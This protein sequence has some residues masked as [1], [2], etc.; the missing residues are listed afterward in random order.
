MN[1]PS[2]GCPESV[3]AAWGDAIYPPYATM[4]WQ[5]ERWDVCYDTA[6]TISEVNEPSGV[7]DPQFVWFMTRSLD[8]SDLPT[9]DSDYDPTLRST[10][11]AADQRLRASVR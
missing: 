3:R 8:N 1:V 9:Y 11:Q 6:K 7:A 4:L 2:E 10:E 5:R